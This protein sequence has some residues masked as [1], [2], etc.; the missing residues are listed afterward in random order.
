MKERG[1]GKIINMASILGKIPGSGMGIY[2]ISKAAVIMLT[3]VMAQELAKDNIQ[4]NAI[5]PG[6]VKTDF[7]RT[8]WQ[9]EKLHDTIVR[10]IPQGRMADPDEI[11]GIALYLASST[12]DYTTGETIFVDGG[13][14]LGPAI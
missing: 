12:S 8:L 1:G 7:S 2:S 10:G 5:A 4:V 13:Q 6:F 9:N 11:V 3:K 14:S